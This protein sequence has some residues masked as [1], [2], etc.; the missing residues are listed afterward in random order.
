MNSTLLK[1]E[2]EVEGED[3]EEVVDVVNLVLG[4]VIQLAHRNALVVVPLSLKSKGSNHQDLECQME[5]GDSPWVVENHLLVQ[6][7]RNCLI[8]WTLLA[9]ELHFWGIVIC[10]TCWT[11]TKVL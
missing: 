3:G 4:V 10:S 6:Q 9:F 2:E 7:F 11:L 5:H 1:E 8:N